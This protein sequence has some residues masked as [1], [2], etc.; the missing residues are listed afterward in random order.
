MYRS[1]RFGADAL[2]IHNTE[3]KT[4]TLSVTHLECLSDLSAQVLT[5]VLSAEPQE[6]HWQDGVEKVQQTLKEGDCAQRDQVKTDPITATYTC[7]RSS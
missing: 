3:G 4:Q 1:A 6:H 2:T 5:Q 7:Y